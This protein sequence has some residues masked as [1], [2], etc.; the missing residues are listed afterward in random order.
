MSPKRAHEDYQ[1]LMAR[2]H[3]DKQVFKLPFLH[4]LKKS[5]TTII[6][7]VVMDDKVISTAQG[8]YAELFPTDHVY[9]NNV[10]TL[11]NYRGKGYGKLAMEALESA[12]RDKWGRQKQKIKMFLTNSPKKENG[13]FYESLGY[14]ARSVEN[15]NTTVIWLK[16]I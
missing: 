16:D 9:V 10:V 13:G 3:G 6:I 14:S 8:S 15:D 2:L 12:A 4:K 1:A 11:D 5:P 7:F